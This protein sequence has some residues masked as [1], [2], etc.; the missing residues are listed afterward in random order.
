M[1]LFAKLFSSIAAALVALFAKFLAFKT[2]LKLAA[3]TTWIAVFTAF[4]VSVFVC[5]SSLLGMVTSSVGSTAGGSWM[6]YFWMGLGMF[7]PSN[8]SAIMACLAS[9][10]ISTSIYKVQ[11]DGI[12]NFGS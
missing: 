3:Y 11:K 4:L 7:V 5:V 8:A 12:M 9:V 2:A 1:P 10:W 6:P